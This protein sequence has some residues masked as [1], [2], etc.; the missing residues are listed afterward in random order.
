MGLLLLL[1]LLTRLVLVGLTSMYLIPLQVGLALLDLGL[2]SKAIPG[3]PSFPHTMVGVHFPTWITLIKVVLLHLNQVVMADHLTI[4][5]D[6]ISGS[7][8]LGF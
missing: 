3:P 5:Q 2:N 6:S 8:H 4:C 1:C 7:N